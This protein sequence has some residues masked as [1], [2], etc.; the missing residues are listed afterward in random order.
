M[1]GTHP[2]LTSP[3][4]RALHTRA[5]QPDERVWCQ[6]GCQPP[7]A[8]ASWQDCFVLCPWVHHFYHSTSQNWKLGILRVVWLFSKV[9]C[10]P[11]AGKSSAWPGTCRWATSSSLHPCQGNSRHGQDQFGQQVTGTSVGP[12]RSEPP[13]FCHSNFSGK[14]SLAANLSFFS[15]PTLLLHCGMSWIAHRRHEADV[16][17]GDYSEA[18]TDW[19]MGNK[20]EISFP[21]QQIYLFF[22]PQRY[23]CIAVCLG[24]RIADTRQMWWRGI[25]ARLPQIGSWATSGRFPSS[26]PVTLRRTLAFSW[27]ASSSCL[28]NLVLIFSAYFQRNWIQCWSWSCLTFCFLIH[29][30]PSALLQEGGGG[31]G[32]WKIC[33]LSVEALCI[34][35]CKGFQM[36]PGVSMALHTGRSSAP[37]AD[38]DGGRERRERRGYAG[39]GGWG[40]GGAAAPPG[41]VKPALVG[42][43]GCSSACSSG[44]SWAGWWWWPRPRWCSA[45]PL[46][47]PRAVKRKHTCQCYQRTILM[48]FMLQCP[49]PATRLSHAFVCLVPAKATVRTKNISSGFRPLLTGPPVGSLRWKAVQCFQRRML[50]QWRNVFQTSFMTLQ[51]QRKKRTLISW[52]Q[53][54]S[55]SEPM[56]A[57]WAKQMLVQSS[58]CR[59]HGPW[60]I[61]QPACSE[62]WQSAQLCSPWLLAKSLS[63]AKANFDP[64]APKRRCR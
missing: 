26:G 9:L 39:T 51:R 1:A 17:K 37:Y 45:W 11:G 16:V 40:R 20:R 47:F 10:N 3:F 18:A 56:Q 53:K 54:A 63:A 58:L 41:F 2:W 55:M 59:V 61:H 49:I 25:T 23:Y 35:P 60:S 5:D 62:R 38:E 44:C 31:N 43:S 28:D 13:C 32:L 8:E 12:C 29:L 50:Q 52:S 21:W 14:G 46:S 19:F 4:I 57:D 30:G 48:F 42:S 33:G 27:M 24:L 64:S 7:H 6:A 36:G 22:L 34:A 15:S